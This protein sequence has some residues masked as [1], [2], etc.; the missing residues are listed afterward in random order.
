[1]S[2][3]KTHLNGYLIRSFYLSDKESDITLVV[4]GH[5]IRAHKFVLS[6]KSIVFKAMFFGDFSEANAKEVVIHDTTLEA[7]QLLLKYCYFEDLSA[8]DWPSND[9]SLVIDVYKVSHLYQIKSLCLLCVKRLITLISDRNVNDMLRFAR[10]YRSKIIL[11]FAKKFI[12]HKK[13][14]TND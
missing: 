12:E 4:D 5:P 14:K 10:L 1:M 3:A 9:H 6:A 2:Y 11:V 13:Q 8:T 7:F